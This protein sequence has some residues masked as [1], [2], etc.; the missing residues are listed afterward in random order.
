[1]PGSLDSQL[2]PSPSF[3]CESFFQTVWWGRAEKHPHEVTAHVAVCWVSPVAPA[4]QGDGAGTGGVGWKWRD[5]H[6][7]AHTKE[8]LG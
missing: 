1:M 2:L 5:G 3:P 6:C 8:P 4:A 7:R